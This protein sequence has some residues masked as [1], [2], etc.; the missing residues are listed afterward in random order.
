MN[1]EQTDS[2]IS[3]V[4][5]RNEDVR[6]NP[7]ID[8]MVAY[9]LVP[10]PLQPSQPFLS[11]PFPSQQLKLTKLEAGNTEI[12]SDARRGHLHNIQEPKKLKRFVYNEDLD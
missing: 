12:R 9:E 6:S 1:R 8:P 10:E 5:N 11:H 2:E 3:E 7:K 4:K